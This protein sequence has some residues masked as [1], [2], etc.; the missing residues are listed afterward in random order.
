VNVISKEYTTIHTRTKQWLSYPL[1]VSAPIV[2]SVRGTADNASNV[3]ACTAVGLSWP[4]A[5]IRSSNTLERMPMDSKVTS[6]PAKIPPGC[7]SS[8]CEENKRPMN[9]CAYSGL[10]PSVLAE[11]ANC[12]PWQA[13]FLFLVSK[14][15]DLLF[16]QAKQVFLLLVAVEIPIRRD[17]AGCEEAR[18]R[19]ENMMNISSLERKKPQ[20]PLNNMNCWNFISVQDK[21]MRALLWG[22]C[23][24]NRY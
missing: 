22:L 11:C 4:S 20:P 9:C 1:P 15:T 16:I 23:S 19:E 8:V 17:I 14:A 10:L 2:M 18:T 7:S 6:E 12:L 24:C 13:V 3:A 21:L 5:L